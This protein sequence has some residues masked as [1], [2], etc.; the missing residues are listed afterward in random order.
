MSSALNRLDL[1]A[2]DLKNIPDGPLKDYVT[3]LKEVLVILDMEYVD[4]FA[5]IEKVIEKIVNSGK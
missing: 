2:G 3:G 5:K 1:I 4:R